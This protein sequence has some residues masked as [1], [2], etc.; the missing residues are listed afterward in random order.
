M[1]EATH[2]RD[3]LYAVRPK[4]QLGTCG[5]HPF[6]WTVKYVRARNCEEAVN[7][8]VSPRNMGELADLCE[9]ADK[10]GWD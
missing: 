1:L 2:L 6:P 8:A 5:F 4:G 9:L 7:K 3:N 10:E